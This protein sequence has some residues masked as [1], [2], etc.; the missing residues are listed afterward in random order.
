[1]NNIHYFLE[2]L[3]YI[4]VKQ[5]PSFIILILILYHTENTSIFKVNNKLSVLILSEVLY[6]TQ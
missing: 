6:K 4:R 2:N 1:M 5:E 3:E